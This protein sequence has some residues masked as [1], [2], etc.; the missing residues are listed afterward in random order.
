MDA[1]RKRPE[2][3]SINTTF[4]PAVP[5]LYVNVDRDRVLKQGVDLAEVYKTL[6]TFM[7]GY[8]VNYF[9]RFG[10]NGR[11]MLKPKGITGLAPKTWA[12]FMCATMRANQFPCPP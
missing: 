10:R 6:Q 3:A 1:V 11:F 5:Q 4:L 7:G 9:N 8:F 2:I 12:C